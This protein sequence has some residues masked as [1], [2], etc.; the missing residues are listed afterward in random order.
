MSWDGTEAVG[1]TIGDR[2]EFLFFL[3]KIETS[4]FAHL[5]LGT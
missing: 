2:I 1:A 3:K 5:D 4:L